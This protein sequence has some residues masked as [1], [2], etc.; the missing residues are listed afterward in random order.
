[1]KKFSTIIMILIAICSG[2][3]LWH[4]YMLTPWTRDARVNAHIIT[5]SP[6]VSGFVTQVAVS[7]NQTI[8]QGQTLFRIDPKRYE[9]AVSQANATLK[10][11]FAA[12]ELSKHKYERR[13]NLPSQDSISSE[14]LETA[15]INMDIAKANYQLAQ[16]RLDEAKLNL[17]RTKITAPFDGTVINL[18]LRSGNYVRQGTSVL[19][20]VEKNSFYITGYFEETKIAKIQLGQPTTIQLMNRQPPLTGK[21]LSIGRAI[22]N[23]NTNTNSQLLPQIQQTFNWVRLSQRIPVN[24][25]LD[26]QVDQ[27]QLSAGMTASI[28]I[29]E[30]TE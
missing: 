6:D 22:A 11:R 18:S 4:H 15:R 8:R 1:M 14:D 30:P 3:W 20:L 24:I 12:W 7:D 17:A 26:D 29:Q 28:T 13:K 10:N 21:V 9:I 19:A 16:A 27:Q 25:Q 23:S 2:Y 5:I